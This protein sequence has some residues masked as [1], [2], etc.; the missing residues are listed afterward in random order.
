MIALDNQKLSSLVSGFHIPPKPAIL[1]EFSDEIESAEP[2]LENIARIISKD[3]SLSALLLKTINSPLFG[4]NRTIADIKQAAMFLGLDKLRFLVTATLLKRSFSGKACISLERFW[5]E[6][7]EVANTCMCLGVKYKSQLSVDELYSVG[8]FH[9]VGIA[10]MAL[11]Y[12]DYVDTLAFANKHPDANITQLEQSKYHCDHATIGYYLAVSWHLPQSICNVILHHHEQRFLENCNNSRDRLT[13]AILKCAENA[14]TYSRSLSH[15]S[16][17]M[18]IKQ[19]IFSELGIVDEDYE[20]L[21]EDFIE[22]IQ[23]R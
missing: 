19:Q 20:D 3:I 18:R 5:D 21:V 7:L 17:W 8:L 2:S 10:A 4:L 12:P 13:Y 11:R 9:N 14:V 22:N 16:E 15:S 6:S 1:T 23:E